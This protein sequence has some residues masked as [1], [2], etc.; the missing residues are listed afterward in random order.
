M[1][2]IGEI[3]HSNLDLLVQRA[4]SQAEVALIAGSSPQYISQLVNKTRD[5]KSGKPREMGSP[6]ARRLEA[7][8]KLP[9]GWMDSQHPSAGETTAPYVVAQNLSHP[10]DSY[11]LPRVTWERLVNENGDLPSGLFVMTLGTDALAPTWPGS[12]EVVWSTTRAPRPGK[13][14][15]I[16]DGY[17]RHH[18]R[19]Y[20]ESKQPGNFVAVALSPHFPPFDSINDG[21]KVIAVYAGQLDPA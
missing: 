16:V 21:A 19:L 4:G 14:V 6:F 18:V 13:P 15:L 10:P 8:F 5:P 9:S 11:L 1:S 3:R 2:P 20:Q 17:G 7:A 12:L